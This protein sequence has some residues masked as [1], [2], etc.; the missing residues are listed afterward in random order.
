M[1]HPRMILFIALVL[2]G[3]PS[4]SDD[5]NADSESSAESG[6]ACGVDPMPPGGASCPAEC[7]G[8]CDGNTC[9]MMCG[10]AGCNDRVITCPADYACHIV[11]DGGDACDTSMV[12]C[13]AGYGCKVDCVQGTDACGDM[14]LDCGTASTCD[15][16]CA[17]V[18]TVCIG[19][20]VTCGAGE[21]SATCAGMSKADVVCGDS[22]DCQQCA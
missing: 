7:T 19:A 3:C 14:A 9:T 12:K 22:C 16:T 5:G 13:P 1:Q 15:I 2:G 17:D 6:G 20:M 11:C 18:Q 4:S 21:C 8:G 10:P